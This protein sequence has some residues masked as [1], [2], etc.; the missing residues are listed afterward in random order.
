MYRRRAEGNL[1]LQA[2][3][4]AT[5]GVLLTLALPP[6]LLWPAALALV[7]LFVLVADSAGFRRAFSLGFWFALGFFS[8]YLL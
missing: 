6:T 1:L 4:A 3:I 8:L 2:I 5:S 7:P